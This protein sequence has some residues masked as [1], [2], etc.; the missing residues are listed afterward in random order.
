M[1]L[2]LKTWQPPPIFLVVFPHSYKK[3][4]ISQPNR[5]VGSIKKTELGRFISVGGLP[6]APAFETPRLR[7]PKTAPRAP[8]PRRP[9]RAPRRS[10]PWAAPGRPGRPPRHPWPPGA[11]QRAA[12][13]LR[14]GATCDTCGFGENHKSGNKVETPGKM[15]GRLCLA[16]WKY[17]KKNS[18]VFHFGGVA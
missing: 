12:N 3:K 10:G 11:K 1:W 6:F 15:R 4:T 7:P 8:L 17:K 14:F 13:S 18:V 16:D 5:Q 2:C 9:P